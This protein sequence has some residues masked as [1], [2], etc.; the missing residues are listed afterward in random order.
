VR[1]GAVRSETIVTVVV[2]VPVQFVEDGLQVWEVVINEESARP[3]LAQVGVR[4]D[5]GIVHLDIALLLHGVNHQ[6][7]NVVYSYLVDVVFL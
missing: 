7:K 2:G 4:G 5:V 6:G 3:V 1:A